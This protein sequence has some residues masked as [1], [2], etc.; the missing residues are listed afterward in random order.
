MLLENNVQA[1]CVVHLVSPSHTVTKRLCRAATIDVKSKSSAER[2]LCSKFEILAELGIK[3]SGRELV[4][5]RVHYVRPEDSMSADDTIASRLDLNVIHTKSLQVNASLF[6]RS[7]AC[8][9]S[10][11]IWSEV[12]STGLMASAKTT[13]GP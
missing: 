7:I 3:I 13:A 2:L 9:A 10:S 6:R 4:N 8:A 5:D 12:S 1:Y 11:S